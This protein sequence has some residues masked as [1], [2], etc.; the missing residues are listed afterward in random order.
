MWN[1]KEN[2]SSIDVTKEDYYDATDVLF[3]KALAKSLR[4]IMNP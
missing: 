3:I 4:V 2:L 1:Q